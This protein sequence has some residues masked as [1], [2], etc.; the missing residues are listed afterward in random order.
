MAQIREVG[1]EGPWLRPL[2]PT[3]TAADSP[4]SRTYVTPHGD[5]RDMAV[6]AD[7]RSVVTCTMAG[8]VRQWDRQTGEIRELGRHDFSLSEAVLSADGRWRS[9]VGRL[10]Y[11]SG[12]ATEPRAVSSAVGSHN[13]SVWSSGDQRRVIAPAFDHTVRLWEGRSAE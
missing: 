4:L 8:I 10:Q 2:R 6:S 9:P 13:V 1:D 7:G 11:G 5:I 12:I 3:L